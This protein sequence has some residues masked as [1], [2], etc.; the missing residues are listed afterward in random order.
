MPGVVSIPHG[1]GHNRNNIS[2]EVAKQHAGIS[3]NDLTDELAIDAL[4][5]T[6]AFNGVMVEV[7]AATNE[8]TSQ[9]NLPL[10]KAVNG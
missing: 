9:E 8:I 7:Q 2:L 5:G 6:A 10:A 4:I 3:V 1:W